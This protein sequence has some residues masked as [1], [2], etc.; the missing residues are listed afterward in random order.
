MV[1]YTSVMIGAEWDSELIPSAP[2]AG[3]QMVHIGRLIG[4]AHLAAGQTAD[5]LHLLPAVQDALTSFILTPLALRL[6]MHLS[7]IQRRATRCPARGGLTSIE[8]APSLTQ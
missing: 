1:P 3:Q 6:S 4:K 7:H 5:F 2:V 8:S